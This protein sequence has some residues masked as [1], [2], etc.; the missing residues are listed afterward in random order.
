MVRHAYQVINVALVASLNLMSRAEVPPVAPL[1][2][3]E[4]AGTTAQGTDP[5]QRRQD[6]RTNKLRTIFDPFHRFDQG[7]INLEGYD[8]GLAFHMFSSCYKLLPDL[9]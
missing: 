3:I 8:V 9:I 4:Y 2:C 1:A 5:V 6:R 7:V